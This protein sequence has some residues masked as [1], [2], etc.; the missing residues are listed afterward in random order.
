MLN[1]LDYC[2]PTP[3]W[4]G[5][6]AYVARH[7][8]RY[9]FPLPESLQNNNTRIESLQRVPL[10]APLQKDSLIGSPQEDALLAMLKR[11][12]KAVLPANEYDTFRKAITALK[13]GTAF[14][15]KKENLYRLCFVLR[16][17][18]DTQAQDLFLNYLHQ[19]ELSARSLDEFILISAL[20]LGLSWAEASG[21]RSHYQAQISS[22]PISPAMLRE[23]DTAEVYHSVIQER[24]HTRND[25]THFLDDAE[26]LAF[27]A[28]TRNTQ[29]LA[30][31]DDVELEALYQAG[32]E[33][34][35]RMVIDYG[36]PEKET[37][38]EYYHS[39][40]GLQDGS[41]ND[42]LT[43][44]E[45][46]LLSNKFSQVFM[47]YDNF[48]LLVQRRRAADISSG[49]FLLNLLKKLLTEDADWEND[50][51]IN[52][53]DPEE[54]LAICNDILASF[55]FPALNPA[56]DSFDRLLLDVYQ[57]TLQEHPSVSN[58]RF[59]ELYLQKLRDYLREIAY[60]IK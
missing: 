19:N 21:I 9:S 58:T 26:N 53:L 3:L 2:T 14:S 60:I 23:G 39:L 15:L 38:Q 11:N 35:V 33:Q 47:T 18:S 13:N 50:F 4:P 56:C 34:L 7:R 28:K 22:Q 17:D 29:Y 36:N 37:I 32:Q 42:A 54:F 5:I 46:S 41:S 6:C 59:Q 16:L 52:F 12:A 40:F 44:E 8:E 49:T 20:K 10:A 31:F 24:I 25:L 51:Y 45:I 1:I 27:F 43:D 57:E 48:C 55:G 30:L